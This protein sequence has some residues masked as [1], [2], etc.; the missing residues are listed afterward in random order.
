MFIATRRFIVLKD[1]TI[2]M[3]ECLPEQIFEDNVMSVTYVPVTRKPKSE[4]NNLSKETQAVVS[5]SV[6]DASTSTMSNRTRRRSQSKNR[7]ESS[8]D[9]TDYYAH[10]RKNKRRRNRN[11]NRSRSRSRSGILPFILSFIY[12]FNSF[13][14]SSWT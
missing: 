1:L 6:N 8:E 13:I 14:Y 11:R 3:A 5:V 10:E 4:G 9:D 7:A 2:K 12:S